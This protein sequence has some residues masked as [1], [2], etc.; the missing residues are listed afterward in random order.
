MQI[1]KTMRII[2]TLAALFSWAALTAQP[3]MPTQNR[4]YTRGVVMPYATATE[5]NE[6]PAK[7]RY[8]ATLS[9]WEA[10]GNRMVAEF[11]APF[12]WTNRQAIL[13]IEAA[14]A[15]YEVWV[16]DRLVGSTSDPTTPADFLITKQTKEGWNSVEVRLENPSS[17]AA[18]SSWRQPAAPWVGSA[19]VVSSPTMGVREVLTKCW[20]SAEE[21]SMANAEVGV[22]IKSYALNN[23]SVRLHYTLDDPAGRT[24]AQGQTDLTLSMRGEDTVRF[25]ARVSDTLLWSRER[26]QHFTLRLKTQREGRYMEYH[27]YPIGLRSVE[28]KEGKILINNRPEELYVVPALADATAQIAADTKR[29]GINTIR[30][31]A[32]PHNEALL[33]ACDSLGLYVIAQAP[34]NSSHSGSS[35][36]KGGNPSNNPR[37]REAYIERATNS[38][39][40]TKRHP[41]VIGF[42]IAEDSS[43]GICLYESYLHLKEWE[44]AR[45]IL[46]PEA[47]GEWNNDR[48][49]WNIK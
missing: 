45:P 29:L 39:H 14:S 33:A 49:D 30:I 22:V 10:N 8:V 18:I 32:G 43:N 27:T 36:L 19:R 5:A 13:R 21:P 17:V 47:E 42:A 31:Q 41:S 26:P 24:V 35:R 37:W 28:V 6:A 25:L 44:K 7:H 15:P 40:A 9:P 46:Y 20:F 48:I 2:L 11:T 12:S 3:L 1:Y 38:Y 16:N 34:I 23:R 4:E